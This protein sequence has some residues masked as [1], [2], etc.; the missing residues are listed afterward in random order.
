MP[1]SAVTPAL[2]WIVGPLRPPRARALCG[3]SLKTSAHRMIH[4]AS[5]VGEPWWQ[6]SPQTHGYGVTS[7]IGE[8][9]IGNEIYEAKTTCSPTGTMR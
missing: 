5:A 8:E 7:E 2:D 1:V 6:R 3:T 9:V 4:G